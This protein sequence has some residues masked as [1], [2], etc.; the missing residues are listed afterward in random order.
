MAALDSSL[1]N[2]F[3]SSGSFNNDKIINPEAFYIID[4]KDKIIDIPLFC[5]FKID[6]IINHFNHYDRLVIPIHTEQLNWEPST[7]LEVLRSIEYPSTCFSRMNFKDSIY[8]IRN[9]IIL[10][11]NF[12]PLFLC[13]VKTDIEN[14]L[15]EAV[16]CIYIHPKVFCEKTTL[17][18]YIVNT[19]VPWLLDNNVCVSV[20]LGDNLVTSYSTTKRY[21]KYP[22]VLIENIDCIETVKNVNNSTTLQ[23]DLEEV[24]LKNLRYITVNP[25]DTIKF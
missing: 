3:Y 16:P 8:Y 11:C 4:V 20:H 25:E 22:K 14:P 9:G 10:D 6:Y 12:K 17:N 23:K 15:S 5:K 24:L 13:T 1:H 18:K 21:Y 2:M 19:I 7:S